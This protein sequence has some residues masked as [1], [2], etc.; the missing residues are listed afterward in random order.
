M[1][2]VSTLLFEVQ[3]TPIADRGQTCAAV[4]SPWRSAIL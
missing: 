3:D 1:S 2:A 4:Y